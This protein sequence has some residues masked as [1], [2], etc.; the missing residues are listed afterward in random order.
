[1]WPNLIWLFLAVKIPKENPEFY[2]Y[3]L[4]IL[5]EFLVPQGAEHH[6]L[7]LEI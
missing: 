4:K 6:H 5:G 2:V 3:N 1:M 7:V